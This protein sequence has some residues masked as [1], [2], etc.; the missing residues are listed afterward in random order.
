M[1]SE[2]PLMVSLKDG[3]GNLSRFHLFLKGKTENVFESI[4]LKSDDEAI[5]KGRQLWKEHNGIRIEIREKETD[6]VVF[7]FPQKEN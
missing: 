3:R 1:S 6:R 7:E 4:S 5:E 2:K